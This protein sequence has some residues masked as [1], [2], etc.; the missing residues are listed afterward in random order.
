VGESLAS[1]MSGQAELCITN[2]LHADL[3]S[4][5]YAASVLYEDDLVL[6][7]RAE[8]H[9]APDID[10]VRAWPVA[11]QA[12]SSRYRQYIEK[13]AREHDVTLDIAYEHSSFDGIVSYVLGGGCVGMVAGYVARSG[14]LRDRLRILD[15]PGFGPRRKVIGIHA[16]RPAPLTDEFIDFFRC[17]YRTGAA[18]SAHSGIP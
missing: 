9:R 17:H 5:Q 6:V 4:G 7:V 16:A 14:P 18:R 12:R 10:L 2:D 8:D 11:T 15:L 13:W 3:A 1:L